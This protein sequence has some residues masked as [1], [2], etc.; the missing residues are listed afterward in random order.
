M[1][2]SVSAVIQLS[3]CRSC[4]S[5]RATSC[6]PPTP[7]THP[8]RPPTRPPNPPAREFDICKGRN[9]CGFEPATAA[10][11]AAASDAKSGGAPHREPTRCAPARVDPRW[12]G[13]RWGGVEGVQRSLGGLPPHA[14]GHPTTARGRREEAAQEHTFQA[15]DSEAAGDVGPRGRPRGPASLPGRPGGRLAP[16]PARAPRLDRGR[17]S[18][19]ARSTKAQCRPGPVPER[20]RRKGFL[21]AYLLTAERLLDVVVGAGLRRSAEKFE[22]QA[23]ALSGRAFS[24]HGIAVHAQDWTDWARVCRE[25]AKC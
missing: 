5:T 9:A 25:R 8:T 13:V 4:A 12:P 7:P 19:A 16:S 24:R 15:R 11:A 17:V 18:A 14:T 3:R 2:A 1:A 6:P 20:R 10:A 21:R 22:A 23:A